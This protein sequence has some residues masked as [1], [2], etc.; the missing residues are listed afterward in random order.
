MNLDNVCKHCRAR[1]FS[2]KLPE[3]RHY[4]APSVVRRAWKQKVGVFPLGPFYK[5]HCEVCHKH[6]AV[7]DKARG[8]THEKWLIKWFGL[9]RRLL[10]LEPINWNY[11]EKPAIPINKD[12][13]EIIGI[14]KKEDREINTPEGF[15]TTS[16]AYKD[17][18][19]KT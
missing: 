14:G 5:V 6:M 1:I 11:R 18:L 10:H 3:K 4:H 15:A 2:D 13:V 8:Q 19:K 16:Y 9:V 17:F 7:F 12:F